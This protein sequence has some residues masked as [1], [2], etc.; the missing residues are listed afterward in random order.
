MLGFA[1]GFRCWSPVQ[2][3][4]APGFLIILGVYALSAADAAASPLS[5]RGPEWAAHVRR[6]SLRA[7]RPAR[8]GFTPEGC[9]RPPTADSGAT[10]L[11]GA[12]RRFTR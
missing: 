3:S 10:R 12:I 9:F 4:E 11:E 8:P 1:F 5:I 7:G 6:K 2:L